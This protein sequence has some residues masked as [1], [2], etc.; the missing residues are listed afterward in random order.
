MP[1]FPD[2]PPVNH[3]RLI[4]PDIRRLSAGTSLW[5]VYFRAGRY[6]SVWYDY[7]AF[8]PL[9]T[10]RFDHHE[11][12]PDGTPWTQEPAILYAALNGPT[13]IAEVFQS[14]RLLDR[15]SRSPWLVEFAPT[16]DLTLLDL[17]TTFP[18]RI[19]ASMAINTGPRPR[20]QRWARR[21][22]EAYDEIDGIIYPSSMYGNEPAVALFERCQTA[23]PR[24]PGFHRALADPA[25]QRRLAVTAHEIGY[26]WL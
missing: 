6:P 3:F 19:G 11:P 26:D 20:A 21:F 24:L 14:T 15:H 18:T 1:K 4:E 8:G 22:Y 16:R 25:L 10:A 5:R 9:S 23:L 7:R 17:C 12:N 2:P 13:C